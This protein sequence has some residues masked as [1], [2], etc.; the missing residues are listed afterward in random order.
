MSFVVRCTK[1]AADVRYEHSQLVTGVLGKQS[2]VALAVMFRTAAEI[3]VLQIKLHNRYADIIP[4]AITK[5][6]EESRSDSITQLLLLQLL[7]PCMKASSL[8]FAAH[9]CTTRLLSPDLAVSSSSVSFYIHLN[10]LAVS[11]LLLTH[12]KV[13]RKPPWLY[14]TQI[15]VRSVNFMSGKS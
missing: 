2:F 12:C 3:D 4:A 6:S 13:N 7:P 1:I 8:L 9:L 10:Y 5:Y 14:A 11:H 15:D